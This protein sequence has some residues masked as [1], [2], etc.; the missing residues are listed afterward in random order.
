MTKKAR[1]AVIGTGW[2]ATTAHLPALR[3]HPDAEVIA[4]ADQ[5]P[6]VLAKAT[7]AYEIDTQYT[8]YQEM[9]DKEDLDGVVV[10]TWNAA[11]Y[12]TVRAC[13]E[14]DLHV[15]VEKPMVV[16]AKQARHL[17]D[18]SRGCGRELIVGYPWHFSSRALRAQELVRSGDLGKVQYVNC[19]FSSSAGDF[20]RGSDELHREVF[21]YPV[22]GP[23]DV[24]SDPERSGGGQGH[25]QITHS[26][27]IMYFITGLRPSTV[28]AFME[29]L[30]ARLDIVDA[31][32]VR[33]DNGAL[34]SVGSTGNLQPG[35]PGKLSVTVHCDRGWLDIDFVS[36]AGHIRHA[37]GTDEE[38]PSIEGGGQPAAAEGG[39]D[40]YP[41][42]AT[43]SNL[44]DVITGKALNGSPCEVGWRTVEMLDA[45]YRSAAS[46][47]QVVSVDSL[48][49]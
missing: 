25:L 11:H 20:I 40:A 4:V 45:A 26:A 24:Y 12:E 44:V 1:V 27:G 36:G 7:E 49:D 5:R 6:E 17:V 31:I 37:D 8:D 16:T 22:V 35:D 2:W 9:L 15:M 34:A 48:Y 32:T 19:H 33:M 10:A 41:I 47:G 21:N 29:N 38:L 18:L 14:H 30:G 23:G 42:H 13:L 43:S 46:G 39:E 28:M 3:A